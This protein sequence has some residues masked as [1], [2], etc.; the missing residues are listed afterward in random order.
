[1]CDKKVKKAKQDLCAEAI[2]A[3][4]KQQYIA[5]EVRGVCDSDGAWVEI[6]LTDPSIHNLEYV[7]KIIPKFQASLDIERKERHKAERVQL[8]VDYVAVSVK[9]TTGMKNKVWNWLQSKFEKDVG[10]LPPRFEELDQ[11]HVGSLSKVPAFDLIQLA[12][13]NR[14]KD[15]SFWNEA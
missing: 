4:L 11:Y 12:L 9:Y 14:L 2:T 7:S 6:K 1:M 5:A 8:K 13:L 10:R 3:L 15:T